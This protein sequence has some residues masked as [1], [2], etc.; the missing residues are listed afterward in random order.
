M[1]GAKQALIVICDHLGAKAPKVDPDQKDP[2]S[3]LAIALYKVIGNM[4][5]AAL[6]LLVEELQQKRHDKKQSRKQLIASVKRVMNTALDVDSTDDVHEP[7]A[8]WK[9][10]PLV[11][12]RKERKT[13]MATNKAATKK[14]TASKKASKKVTKKARTQHGTS[15]KKV[16]KKAATKKS[17][18]RKGKPAAN[19]LTKPVK[20]NSK[21][22]AVLAKF[23]LKTAK[24]AEK[25]ASEIGTNRSNILSHLHDLHKYHG[26]GYELDGDGPVSIHLPKGC[27]TPWAE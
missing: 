18:G 9:M 21:R 14:K 15:K 3:V 7:T 16:A 20:K 24:T 17:T 6:G 22:G 13:K 23:T 5:D 27:K 1:I 10:W 19:K 4:P 12:H 11:I 26:I 2:R 8:A 25:A